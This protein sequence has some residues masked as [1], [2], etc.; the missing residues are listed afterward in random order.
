MRRLAA[1]STASQ[2]LSYVRI[3]KLI[4]PIE[5]DLNY[6]FQV[7]HSGFLSATENLGNSA[8]IL[9][10]D[11]S[12]EQESLFFIPIV[13]VAIAI[14]VVAFLTHYQRRVSSPA[15][16]LNLSWKKAIF[17]SVRNANTMQ[18]QDACDDEALISHSSTADDDQTRYENEEKIIRS[19]GFEAVTCSDRNTT[20]MSAVDDSANSEL[21]ENFARSS[22]SSRFVYSDAMYNDELFDMVNLRNVSE[23]NVR[24]GVYGDLNDEPL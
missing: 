14:A 24:H 19:H 5:T 15:T 12:L 18:F 8:D 22:R 3:V 20:V 23:T 2:P 9:V 6:K 17:R 4:P 11:E 1:L 7:S 10:I 16:F 13:I 21:L